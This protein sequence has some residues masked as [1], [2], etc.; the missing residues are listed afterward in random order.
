[1]PLSFIARPLYIAIVCDSRDSRGIVSP[2]PH[3]CVAAI[4]NLHGA[5][6]DGI[7]GPPLSLSHFV[8]QFYV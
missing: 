1:M 5:K 6:P 3:L 8:S 4:V 2:G 7:L